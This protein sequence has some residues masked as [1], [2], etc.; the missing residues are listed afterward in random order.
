MVPEVKRVYMAIIIE[1]PAVER[2][3]EEVAALTAH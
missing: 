2:L 1:N 3:I